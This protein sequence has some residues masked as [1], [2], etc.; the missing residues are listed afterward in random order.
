MKRKE[1]YELRIA[2]IA[3]SKS[4]P[5]TNTRHVHILHVAGVVVIPL[6]QAPEKLVMLLQIALVDLETA[7]ETN[8]AHLAQGGSRV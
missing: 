2:I 1:L 7:L 8:R 4:T 5:R 6:Q 3:G